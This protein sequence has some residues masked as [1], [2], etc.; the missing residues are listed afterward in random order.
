MSFT[1]YFATLL[2]PVQQPAPCRFAPAKQAPAGT[3]LQSGSLGTMTVGMQQNG[4]NAVLLQVVPITQLPAT[5]IGCAIHQSVTCNF[6]LKHC[7]AGACARAACAAV[8]LLLLQAAGA[9]CDRDRLASGRLCCQQLRTGA[10]AL[11]HRYTVAEFSHGCYPMYILCLQGR[12]FCFRFAPSDSGQHC[13]S[14][15]QVKAYSTLRCFSGNGKCR[16][17]KDLMLAALRAPTRTRSMLCAKPCKTSI[18][19]HRSWRRS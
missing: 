12:Q 2:Q 17:C 3:W 5:G 4:T 16:V 6:L 19:A 13:Q 7:G 8:Q 11:T 15:L 10:T 18:F 1:G 14:A 9:F